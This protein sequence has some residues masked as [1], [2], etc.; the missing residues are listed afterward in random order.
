MV[1]QHNLPDVL[2]ALLD[3]KVNINQKDQ[4]Q[5]TPLITA[6]TFNSVECVKILVSE[7]ANLN[8]LNRMHNTA[9]HVAALNNNMEVAKYLV[10]Q[11][12][13]I[14]R[15]NCETKTC[16]DLAED[17]ELQEMYDMLEVYFNREQM[18]RNRN[19]LLKI[20]LNK[21]RT[22]FKN[23]SYGVFKEIIKYA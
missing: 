3:L 18:W 23:L 7:G 19:C 13:D 12:A 10:E 11:K 22:M 1:C 20:Y 14:M 21:E 8:I 6:A 9:L 17:R 15:K 16:L 5:I 2:K 4:Y